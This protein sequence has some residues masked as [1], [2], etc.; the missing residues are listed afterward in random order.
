MP[1]LDEAERRQLLVEWNDTAVEYPRDKCIHELFEKQVKRTPD[2]AAVIFGKQ[3]LTYR[4]LNTRANKLAHY[5]RLQ[6]VVA[7]SRVGIWMDRSPDMM[8]ALLGTLKAGGAYVPLDPSYPQER[9]A[10]MLE[11]AQAPVLLTREKFLKDLPAYAGHVV[12]MDKDFEAIAS[13]SEENP[14]SGITAES[15]AYVIYT[16]GSTG[17]PKGVIGLHR[18]AVNRLSWMWRVYPFKAGE[19][20]CQKTYLSFLDSVWEIFGPLLKGVPAVIIPEEVVKD[21]HLLVDNLAAARVSR[22]V[23]VPSLL[24]VL[25]DSF[26]DLQKRLFDLKIWV[27]SGEEISVEL[28]QRFG[29]VMPEAKLIN[30]YGSSEVSADVTCYEVADGMQYRCI[31]I[32]RPIDNTSIYILDSHLQPVPIGVPGELYIGGVGLARGYLNQPDLTAERFI[33][34]PFG[35]E[36]VLFKTG[37]LGRYLPDGNIEYLGRIDHQVKIRGFRI[38][39][40]EIESVLNQHPAVQETV[41]VV[42]EDRPGDKRLAAYVVPNPEQAAVHS[43]LR[44]FL[45]SKLPDYMVPSAFV[46]LEAMPLTPNRKVDRRALPAPDVVRPELQEAFVAPRSQSEE[47][48]AGIW[49][50]VLGLE[51]IGVHDNFFELGGHSLLATRVVARIQQEFQVDLKLM[52][53]FKLPTI[54]ELA[55]GIEGLLWINAGIPSDDEAEI[56]GWGGMG[57]MNPVDL[58]SRLRNHNIRLWAENDQL[59]VNAPKGGMTEDLL[60]EIRKNKDELLNLVKNTE[61]FRRAVS[62]VPVERTETLRL[63]FAQKRLWFLYHLFPEIPVYNV[64]LIMRL[65]GAMDIPALQKSLQA[66]IDRHESLRTCFPTID[67]KPV[68]VIRDDCPVPLLEHNLI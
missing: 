49:S 15:A 10:F 62:L 64:P 12:C 39:L 48:V 18:G 66:L 31:P 5:L 3:R 25:L 22:I 16:S 38:E 56:S 43:E 24:R 33:P 57:N 30:L 51:R 14:I 23:L 37:D 55:K 28:A 60:A 9:L 34:S 63:S 32:G 27:T 59:R 36:E 19:V 21:P 29:Q 8:V 50:N 13:A 11:D 53:F 42:R 67:G 7:E 44:R 61:R 35:Q 47:L 4:E 1:I 46:E 41:A 2:A 65:T 40:E 45:K 17:K 26:G 52:D 20:C 54:A 6:G 58:L 68:Q